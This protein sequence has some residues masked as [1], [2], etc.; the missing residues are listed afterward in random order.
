M[1]TCWHLSNPRAPSWS[2]KPL[3][4]HRHAVLSQPGPKNQAVGPASIW[5]IM[6]DPPKVPLGFS[7]SYGV[8]LPQRCNLSPA[9][10]LNRY[11]I[12]PQ[13]H[14]LPFND[15]K[16]L[17]LY[18][19]RPWESLRQSESVPGRVSDAFPCDLLS[20]PRHSLFSAI[21]KQLTLEAANTLNPAVANSEPLIDV[22]SL[23]GRTRLAFITEQ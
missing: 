5:V 11:C 16:K 20:P 2:S 8:L 1:N 22:F 15:E 9:T 21:C 6:R 4:L 17:P 3:A 19:S 18:S 12:P 14:G 10:L 13:R 23:R 7:I